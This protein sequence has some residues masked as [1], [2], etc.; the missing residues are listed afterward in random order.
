ME[1]PAPGSACARSPARP[2]V[3]VC[4]CASVCTC[5]C[6]C[7]CGPAQ[8]L[9]FYIE[10]LVKAL[11]GGS[12]AFNGSAHGLEFGFGLADLGN[13]SIAVGEVT[14]TGSAPVAWSS[15]LCPLH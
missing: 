3:C 15:S 8:V 12:A 7:V 10:L 14:A 4:A 5:V 13:M 2:R 6:V 11:T 9:P 1:R